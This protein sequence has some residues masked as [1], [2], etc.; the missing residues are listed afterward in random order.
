MYCIY[1]HL[2]IY[3]CICKY[4]NYVYL[5]IYL[6]SHTYKVMGVIFYLLF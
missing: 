6:N 5:S 3:K 2:Y 4:I 1:V